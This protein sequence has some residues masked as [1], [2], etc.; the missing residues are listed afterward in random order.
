MKPLITA[1][2]ATFVSKPFFQ[3]SPFYLQA[4]GLG[5]GRLTLEI[6][7]VKTAGSNSN[8]T[9]CDPKPGD[10]NLV[11]ISSLAYPDFT[12][13]GLA[14]F[15]AVPV[16]GWFRV[17]LSADSSLATADVQVDGIGIEQAV[18]I[19]MPTACAYCA[20]VPML[21]GGF[22]FSLSDQRDPLATVEMT[23]CAGD[24][25]TES[26]WLYPASVSGAT[27]KV[28]D[29]DGAVIGYAKN[30]SKC[31]SASSANNGTC[32]A[33]AI[34]V[35]PVVPAADIRLTALAFSSDGVLTATL[36]N[37]SIVTSNPLSSC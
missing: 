11:V 12:L 16:G 13:C 5:S 31:A 22:G 29:C 17:I 27:I 24:T 3:D 37:G 8:G 7:T 33:S 6:I 34:P 36:S 1:G 10:E 14:P 9:L 4:L 18:A 15:G 26:I 2:G 19:G 21:D 32:G 30:T 23:P 20:S 25:T 28:T 35:V